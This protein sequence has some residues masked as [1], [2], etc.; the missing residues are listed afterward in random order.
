MVCYL[1]KLVHK[2]TG[3]VQYKRGI[4]KWL[5]PLKRFEDEKYDIFD[6]SVLNLFVYSNPSCVKANTVV[7]VFEQVLNGLWPPKQRDFNVE[8]YLGEEAGSLNDTGITEFIYLWDDQT[9]EQLVNHF[10]MAKK[11]MW[12]IN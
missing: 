7:N 12:K 4:T 6:I 8:E 1:V 5:D 10:E 9:E 3:L 2:K 11:S